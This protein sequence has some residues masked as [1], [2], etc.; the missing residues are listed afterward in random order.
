MHRTLFRTARHLTRLSS[1][2][3]LLAFGSVAAWAE[4][5]QTMER[6]APEEREPVQ[7][8]APPSAGQLSKITHPELRIELMRM[9]E[10]DQAARSA[11]T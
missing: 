4:A 5:Q 8:F 11:A 7:V 6:T 1:S 3:F 10:E 2:L 9:A